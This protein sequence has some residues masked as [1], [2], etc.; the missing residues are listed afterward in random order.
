MAQPKARKKLIRLIQKYLAGKASPEEEQFIKAYYESF[1]ATA[2]EP[3][4]QEGQEKELLGQEMKAAIWEQIDQTTQHQNVIPLYKRSWFRVSVA[5]AI[6]V[7]A[8][9]PVYY[10]IVQTPAPKIIVQAKQQKAPVHD[11]LPGGNKATLTLADGTLIDLGKAANGVVATDGGAT[12]SKK[13]D[14][15]LEYNG[16]L[17]EVEGSGQGTERSRSAAYNT[18]TTPTGGQYYVMLPDGSRVWLNAASSLKYPTAFNSNERLVYLTGEAYFEITKNHNKPFRVHFIAPASG[19]EGREGVIEVLGTHFNV[20]A[21]ADEAMIKTTLLEGGI[22]E[23]ASTAD[24]QQ[25]ERSVILN[26][27]QQAQLKN[28]PI[29]N[30]RIRVIND[31][32]TE[33]AIAWKN[34]LFYFDNV[35][36]QAIMRQL[37]R[38]YKV[39]VVF[40]GRIPARRFAGQVS[41]SSNLSQVL[42]ILELSKV[43]F[44]IEGNLVI[45]LP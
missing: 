16:T 4:L 21:Y 28:A 38:W 5:A 3:S 17:S 27:G 37:E 35:D 29:G 30:N 18:L 45:V 43:H 44:T 23:W 10:Y 7:V 36:I 22:R 15:R 39:Q 19:N 11:A 12:V 34:G 32:D 41:R 24:I 2:G 6:V 26:P 31:A 33:E 40:K 20:N 13:E 1:D 42:K 14:G 9:I 25:P 8:F